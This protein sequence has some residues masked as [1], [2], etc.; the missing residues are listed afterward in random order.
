MHDRR[1]F[2]SLIADVKDFVD[3]LQDLTKSLYPVVYQKD[4][5]KLGVL[6]IDDLD[7]LQSSNKSLR[8]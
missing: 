3:G 5:V 2:L 6:Q 4:Y 7:T 8:S 1:K